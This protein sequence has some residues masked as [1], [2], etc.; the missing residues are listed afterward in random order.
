M[1][2]LMTGLQ[3]FQAFAWGAHRNHCQTR[4]MNCTYCFMSSQSA[5]YIL[6]NPSKQVA[7]VKR[8]M[9]SRK[10]IKVNVT[11]HPWQI[12]TVVSYR[13]RL[14]KLF[15]CSLP[16]EL[17]LLWNWKKKNTLANKTKY[18]NNYANKITARRNLSKRFDFFYKWNCLRTERRFVCVRRK[19]GSNQGWIA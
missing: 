6:M 11:L 1:C 18:C 3:M 13:Y 14:K 4:W 8:S 10:Q 9:A 7:S 2:S 15:S 19:R 17:H 12:C 5:T 16:V